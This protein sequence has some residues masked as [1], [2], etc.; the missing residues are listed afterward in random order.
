MPVLENELVFSYY[1]S[2]TFFARC[3]ALIEPLVLVH[4]TRSCCRATL[5]LTGYEPWCNCTGR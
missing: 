4:F 3:T 5:N 1:I 2:C